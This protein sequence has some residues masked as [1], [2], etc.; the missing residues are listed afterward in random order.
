MIFKKR[1]IDSISWCEDNYYICFS[2]ETSK[3][4]ILFIFNA[5]VT[6]CVSLGLCFKILA[7]MSY[8]LKQTK[9]ESWAISTIKVKKIN[10]IVYLWYE[11]SHFHLNY[12]GNHKLAYN[13]LNV[14]PQIINT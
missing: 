5:A 14:Y 4:F 2:L 12:P 3:N 8:V 6:M 1:K 13:F 11:C 7:K 9:V 10:H